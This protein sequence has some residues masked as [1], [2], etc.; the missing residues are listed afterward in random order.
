MTDWYKMNPVDWNDGTDDLTLEQEG[1]Y[2]RICNAIYISERPIRD[3]MFVVAGLL[4][5]SD[6]KARRLV[7]DLVKAGKLVIEDGHILNRRA[8]DEVS[9]RVRLRMERQSN[10][11]RGGS[12]TAEKRA[13]ALKDNEEA[14]ANATGKNAA[15]EIRQEETREPLTPSEKRYANPTVVLQSVLDPVAAQRWVTH[16]EE[17]GKRPTSL[18]AEQQAAVLKEL[19]AAGC[20]P[21]EAVRYA[22]DRGWVS[23]SVEFFRNAGLVPAGSLAPDREDWANRLAVWRESE[24]W[25][26]AWGPKP[27]EI[28]C[29]APAELLKDAA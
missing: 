4:R 9:A 19:R 23:L 1:A 20:K 16:C 18:Q 24:T 15:E 7:D 22:I 26:P 25:S 10:G 5:C 11:S 21:A 28:G 3:N 2:L 27:G 29:R 13:N 8:V 17:R 6:R 14:P 12:K